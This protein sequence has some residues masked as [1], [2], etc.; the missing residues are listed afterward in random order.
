V[1][2]SVNGPSQ[3]N[4]QQQFKVSWSVQNIGIGNTSTV[5]W[6]DAIYLSNDDKLDSND[7][8][9]GGNSHSRLN[10]SESY[11]DTR[12][13][14]LP[15]VPSR[16]YYIFVKIDVLNNLYESNETNNIKIAE[17]P[18]IVRVPDLAVTTIDAPTRV[19][20]QQQFNFSWTV[21]NQGNG[22]ISV[23]WSDYIYF[24]NDS[25]LDSSDTYLTDIYRN[26]LL[27]ASESYNETRTSTIPKVP[28]GD[29]YILAK[30]D[31]T[32]RL[33]ESNESNNILAH[34]TIVQMPD[35]LITEVKVP[36]QVTLGKP[37]EIS[38]TVLNHGLGN[39]TGSWKD[40]VYVSADDELNV[41]EDKFI[42]GFDHTQLLGSNESYN[43]SR[44]I[45][46][47]NISNGNYLLVKTDYANQVPESREWNN[48]FP[49]LIKIAE[50]GKEGGL[51]ETF[52]NNITLSADIIVQQVNLNGTVI[53]GD[54]NG[55]LDFNDL[56]IITIDS[57]TFKDNGF[58][59]GNWTLTLEGVA[60]RGNWHGI[61]YHDSSA[62]RIY[63]KGELSGG[64]A[65][66]T[67]DGYLVESEPGSGVYDRYHGIWRLARIGGLSISTSLSI[68]GN[69]TYLSNYS[70]PSIGIYA[71]QTSVVGS[72]FGHYEEY[73]ST[74]LTYLRIDDET[75]PYTGQGFFIISYSSSEGSGEGWGYTEKISFGAVKLRGL[76]AGPISGL[77]LGE[78]NE[79]VS[80]RTLSL[81]I[82]R[83]DLGLPPMADLEV[84]TW[85][86]SRVSPGQTIDYIIEYRNDG[87]NNAYNVVVVDKLSPSVEYISSSIGGIYRADR[88]EVFW[89]I[90]RINPK[91]TGYL[92]VRATVQ[93]GL[94][95]GTPLLNTAL[96]DTTSQEID[97][98]ERPWLRPP[99]NITD[100]LNY[101]TV[102][103][104]KCL[105]HDE[106]DLA[107]S[108]N[109]NLSNLLNYTEEIGY[110][111]TNAT[112]K[113]ILSD[114][115]ELLETI[116]YHSDKPNDILF[117]VSHEDE[118]PMIMV[119]NESTISF[120]DQ[121]GSIAYNFTNTTHLEITCSGNL[122]YNRSLQPISGSETPACKRCLNGSLTA[123]VNSE[124]SNC[125]SLTCINGCLLGKV[126]LH[127]LKKMSKMLSRF[128]GSRSCAEY[129]LTGDPIAFAKCSNMWSKEFGD[130]VPYASEFLEIL[131]CW[132]GCLYHY[133]DYIRIPGERKIVCGQTPD[134][135]G[136]FVERVGDTEFWEWMAWAQSTSGHYEITYYWYEDMCVW[137]YLGSRDCQI[138]VDGIGCQPTS[139]M[140]ANEY[141]GQI[142]VARDPNI[143][144]GP[145]DDVS[146]GQKL[147][148]EVEYENEGEGIAFGVYFTD[149][150]DENLNASSLEIGP[151]LDVNTSQQIGEPGTYDPKTRTITW[152]VGEVSSHQGGRS[153]LNVSVNDDASQGTE[154][155]N[156]ATVYFPSVPETTKTNGII[157]Q[158]IVPTITG[159]IFNDIN[160]NSAKDASEPGLSDWTI[161]LTKPD[162]TVITTATDV[163]GNY[164]FNNVAPGTYI[165]S[166]DLKTGW[167][168]TYPSAPGTHTVT[169]SNADCTS[170]DFGNNKHNMPPNTPNIPSG[171]SSGYTGTSYSYSTSAT[172]P[173]DDQVKYTFDWGDGTTSVTSLVNSGTVASASHT[174]TKAG[175][176]QVKANATDSKGATSG[177]SSSLTITVNPNKSPNAPGKPSGSAKC[178]AGSSYSYSTSATDPDKDNVKYTFDWGD[179]TKSE[180]GLVKSGI[181]SS[182]THAWSSTGTYLV[183]ANATDSKGATSGYSS[184][185]TITV[186]PNKSP[187]APGKPSGSAKCV[188]GS[189]YSYSTSAS[190]PDKDNV[191]YTFDWGDGTKSETGLVKSGI[192]SSATHAWSTPGTYLIK[193]NATDFKGA[194]S[195]YSSSLTITVNPNKPPTAPSKPS[196]AISGYAWAVYSYSVS[197]KD[198]DKDN[199]KYT[200]DW[201]DGTKSETGLVKSGT[202]ASATHAWSTPGTYLVKAN[203]T[204]FKGAVSG[205]SGSLSVTISPNSIPGTPSVP[206]GTVTGKIKKSYSYTT[207]VTDPDGDKLKYTFDWGDGKTSVTSFVNSGTSASSSHAWSK[208]GTYQV[209][210]MATDS[211]GAPSISWSSQL[212]V[213]IT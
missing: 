99:F 166:E 149:T 127:L 91:E 200:F 66:G 46:I 73:L 121:E 86:P 1:V 105:T 155:I 12:T 199:V 44:T 165:V 208:A 49:I 6:Y 186:N 96:I 142:Q 109:E 10:A 95:Q 42:A 3:V 104:A 7:Q 8:Q 70:Y 120:G 177:Y 113:A 34:R 111:Y 102:K 162:K 108:S 22:N 147:N 100:Y 145:E 132:E 60:Y 110:K 197:A 164:S 157:S 90:D 213:T 135:F 128:M 23:G 77:V 143:K 187:N 170:I 134:D 167:I 15:N 116:M 141:Q 203:A 124:T 25:N 65:R 4:T 2:T 79:Q 189:S 33:Y 126:P 80:P 136:E 101:I 38:W 43:L 106:F 130:G 20:P 212:A 9:L 41:S 32:S 52:S 118:N 191:K 202:K 123:P 18:F 5:S 114:N 76:L 87:I 64:E 156:F 193:A 148:Y 50:I 122:C 210:V 176:Y 82:E 47:S 29:Y 171:P 13:V 181:K 173:D 72:T 115:T 169:I 179:G 17:H 146:P 133:E 190:D 131:S 137:G 161:E 117:I 69:L 151:V 180:T 19:S 211:K 63:L 37:F 163:N 139:E 158:V 188:A 150:L 74:V 83:L 160:N 51:N 93:W 182:A 138:C 11:S 178:V 71:L 198:P 201:S 57:D 103:S 206:T 68:A 94:A 144:Y 183:K 196:G 58:S 75:N 89:K 88:H 92:T 45:T 194:V 56:E 40:G 140:N 85:G 153:K 129:I 172:D 27:N 26:K 39:S 112:V 207:S 174:W 205:Y 81:T 35:L 16:N 21:Q 184:S 28:L 67:A 107:L 185:L 159:M 209:K 152:F 98:F 175:T 125:N 55:T 30:T 59:K 195:G 78:L 53:S 204:D 154:I 54:L 61:S 14:S 168:Q 84:K 97:R 31:A 48:I 36:S 192:K 24:S 119:V 62:S